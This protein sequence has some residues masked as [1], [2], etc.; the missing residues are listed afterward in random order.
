M[1]TANANTMCKMW[2]FSK[3]TFTKTNFLDCNQFYYDYRFKKNNL[4]T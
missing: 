4:Y 2:S 1:K 3:K